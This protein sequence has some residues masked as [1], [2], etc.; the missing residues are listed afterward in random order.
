MNG[1]L[2]V[3]SCMVSIGLL[4]LIWYSVYDA[5]YRENARQMVRTAR[6]MLF[7]FMW[8]KGHSLDD[9]EYQRTMYVLDSI[10]PILDHLGIASFFVEI[11]FSYARGEAE[12]WLQDT[13]R[14]QLAPPGTISAECHTALIWGFGA[15][16]MQVFYH[17][18]RSY[19]SFVMSWAIV[20][21]I[22]AW[23]WRR[24]TVPKVALILEEF[25]QLMANMS[26]QQRLVARH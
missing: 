15:V 16:F 21:A 13:K 14:Q 17:G 23:T 1:Y 7:D 19:V 22:R 4:G 26:K 20:W 24:A 6:T 12:K 10:E 5:F 2:M 8:A 9:P 25:L 3:S 18:I 11:V